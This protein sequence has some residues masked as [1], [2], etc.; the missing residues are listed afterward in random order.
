MAETIKTVLTADSSELRSE[1]QKASAAAQQYHQRVDS[2]MRKAGAAGKSGALG[3]LAFSQAVEDVQYGIRGVLNNIPQMVL[4]FGGTAGIAGAFSLAA[5]AGVALYPVLERLY[6]AADAKRIEAGAEAWKKV[7]GEGSKALQLAVSEA[8]LQQN[9]A[10]FAQQ[11]TTA[12]Q[13]QLRVQNGM[14]VALES[15]V[16]KR[17][18]AAQLAKEIQEAQDALTRARGGVVKGADISAAQ[19]GLAQDQASQRAIMERATAEALRLSEEKQSLISQAANEGAARDAQLADLRRRLVESEAAVAQQT[20]GLEGLEKGRERNLKMGSL[21]RSEAARDEIKAAVARLEGETKAAEAVQASASATADAAISQ[22]ERK[23]EKANE[24]VNSLQKRIEHQATL[25]DLQRQ[26]EEA[27]QSGAKVDFAEEMDILRARAVGDDERVKSLERQSAIEDLKLRLM[28]EQ[29]LEERAALKLAEERVD[30]ERQAADAA[31][32]ARR[33][34]EQQTGRED[35][36][37][38]MEALRLEAS[39]QLEMGEALRDEVRMRRE[40]VDLARELGISEA[41]AIELLR[42]KLGLEDEARD[43]KEEQRRLERSG[44]RDSG[45]WRR[46]AGRIFKYPSEHRGSGLSLGELSMGGLGDRG[47]L[48]GRLPDLR[49]NELRR[50]DTERSMMTQPVHPDESVRYL[51]RGVEL[52][53]QTLRVF[54]K[55]GIV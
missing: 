41:E 15:E 30:L 22:M 34:K 54:Q 2:G 18:E 3:F 37:A 44:G 29:G 25:N 28:K 4:G 5:V 24:E 13:D 51:M 6:G 49:N 27:Q 17:A 16:A 50:R 47:G 9:L 55:L 33:A 40:A 36:V 42:E 38:E 35:F 1:F 39:G 52:Q 32:N 26:A 46:P 31:E 53:E 14:I 43:V 23:A 7:Y 10:V 12:M 8:A 11:R 21:K 48:G 20:K 45:G 19:K